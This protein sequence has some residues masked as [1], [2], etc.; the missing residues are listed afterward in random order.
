MT[1]WELLIP[2][3]GLNVAQGSNSR[4]AKIM[5]GVGDNPGYVLAA[6]MGGLLA[7]AALEDIIDD[8]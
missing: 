1:V 8:D 5:R 4:A 6:A 3:S 2:Y 7:A